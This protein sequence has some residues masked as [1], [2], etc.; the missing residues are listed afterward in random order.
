M[1][2]TVVQV[3]YQTKARSV[4]IDYMMLRSIVAINEGFCVTGSE[5][6]YLRVWPLDFSDYFLEAEHEGPVQSV[7]VSPDGLKLVVGT[8]S[9]TLGVLDVST[10]NYHTRLKSY[11]HHPCMPRSVRSKGRVRTVSADGTIRFWSLNTPN[12][13]MSLQ[14]QRK[15]ADA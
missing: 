11:E 8:S 15:D 12:S 6:K 14:H 9:G 4:F 3:N 7:D 13:C 5:D 2:G 1:D 10:H